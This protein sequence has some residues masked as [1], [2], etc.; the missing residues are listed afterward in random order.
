MVVVVVVV[1]VF[2][3]PGMGDFKSFL[4]GVTATF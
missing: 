3:H 2:N 1:V 4:M